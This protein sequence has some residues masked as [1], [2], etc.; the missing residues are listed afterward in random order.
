MKL[1]TLGWRKPWL[2]LILVGYLNLLGF[3]YLFD[4][5]GMNHTRV[6]EVFNYGLFHLEW[7][8]ALFIFVVFIITMFFMNILLFK[9]LVRTLDGREALLGSGEEKL[10][11]I[12]KSLADA[13]AGYEKKQ[14]E[15]LEAIS[16]KVHAVSSEAKADAAIITEAAEKKALETLGNATKALEKEAAAAQQE[17]KTIVV[18]LSSHIQKKVLN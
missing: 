1:R 7:T 9:P 17:A 3:F 13:K 4:W 10:D 18:E 6:G 8:T 2:L 12:N 14:L 5:Q 16:A 15:T 11:E